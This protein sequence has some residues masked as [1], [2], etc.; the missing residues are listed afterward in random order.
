MNVVDSMMFVAGICSG[1]SSNE[2]IFFY[3]LVMDL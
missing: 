3:I 2:G 1:N